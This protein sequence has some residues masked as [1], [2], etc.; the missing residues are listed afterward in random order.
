MTVLVHSEVRFSIHLLSK[1]DRYQRY[2]FLSL[3]ISGQTLCG[4]PDY[5]GRV[6]QEKRKKGG[7]KKGDKT[8]VITINT[9]FCNQQQQ[10]VPLLSMYYFLPFLEV[11]GWD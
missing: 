2:H 9:V 7:K 8:Y 10:T 1:V 4:N 6:K 5:F 11:F 3:L